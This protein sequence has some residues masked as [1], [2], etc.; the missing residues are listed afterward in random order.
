MWCIGEVDRE[1]IEKLEDVLATYEKP[2]DPVQP[3]VC[4]D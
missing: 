2:Y 4:L 1:Y 3:V